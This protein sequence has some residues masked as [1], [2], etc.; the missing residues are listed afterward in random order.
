[1]CRCTL[2]IKMKVDTILCIL[3]QPLVLFLPVDS[4]FLLLSSPVYELAVAQEN[5]IQHFH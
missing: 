2:F 5:D 3:E 1:M 4:P